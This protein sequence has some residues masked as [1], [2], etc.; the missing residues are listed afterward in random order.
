[1][2]SKKANAIYKHIC[3]NYHAYSVTANA[4]IALAVAGFAL[5]GILTTTLTATVLVAWG[6]F[7]AFVYGIGKLIDQEVDDLDKV[8]S[9]GSCNIECY[10]NNRIDGSDTKSP[11]K[12]APDKQD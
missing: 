2:T 3:M 11:T 5:L 7:F 8:A 6:G 12:L 9:H 4:M 10:P 1:M